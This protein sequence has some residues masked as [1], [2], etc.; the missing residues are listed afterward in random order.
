[1]ADEMLSTAGMEWYEISNWA[2]PGHACRHNILYWSQGEYAGI[3]CAAHGHTAGRRWWNVRTPERYID[4][5]T[6]GDVAEAGGETLDDG[7][8]AEERF[9][10]AL[11]TIGGA[12][13]LAGMA[14]E[15]ARLV[16]GELA[17]P[18]GAAGATRVRLTRAGRLLATDVT[19][20]LL[21]AA[22]PAVAG[23]R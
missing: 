13:P 19:A 14:H 10:L 7:G 8:R 16:E 18:A 12:E 11:R 3:G 15:V 17:E 6:S 2:R 5:I 4:R 9:A 21:A 20:R 23:T 22:A 1:V